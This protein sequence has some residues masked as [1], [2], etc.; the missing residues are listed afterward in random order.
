MLIK[1]SQI[2]HHDHH[3]QSNYNII[4]TNEEL[5]LF[6]LHKVYT[7]NLNSIQPANTNSQTPIFCNRNIL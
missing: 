1:T 5:A 7:K 6:S 4:A 2:I 3:L